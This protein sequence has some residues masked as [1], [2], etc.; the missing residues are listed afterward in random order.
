M[1]RGVYLGIAGAVGALILALALSSGTWRRAPRRV[2]MSGPLSQERH[3]ASKPSGGAASR[4]LHLQEVLKECL[5][6]DDDKMPKMRQ[7]I[8]DHPQEMAARSAEWVEPLMQDGRFSNVANLSL[9]LIEALPA[10]TRLIVKLQPGIAR[11]LL[12]HGAWE[13]ALFAAKGMYNVCPVDQ[14]D[15]AIG[16][17][18]ECLRDGRLKKDPQ[19]IERFKT[20]QMLGSRAVTPGSSEPTTSA[21]TVLRSIMANR[22]NNSIFARLQK[23]IGS[24]RGEDYQAMVGRGN[25]F[26]LIDQPEKAKVCFERAYQIANNEQLGEA[27]QSLARVMKAQDGGSG[28]AAAWLARQAPT[29]AISNSHGIQ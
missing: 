28:R 26:L 14:T 20:E 24:I 22:R 17:M 15:A 11:S 13:R 7:L 18:V 6:T 29:T 23:S 16:L 9:Q 27:T 12:Y 1:R 5:G 10:D 19:V 3:P 25:L 21:Q 2:M 8:Q 4:E